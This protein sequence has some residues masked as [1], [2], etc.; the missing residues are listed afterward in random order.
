MA[1]RCVCMDSISTRSC[2]SHHPLAPLVWENTCQGSCHMFPGIGYT[3]SRDSELY[4][5]QQGTAVQL[6]IAAVVLLSSQSGGPGHN[7][8]LNSYCC[9]CL[10]LTGSVCA[11]L[12]NINEWWDSGY[13]RFLEVLMIPTSDLRALVAVCS[14]A[15]IRTSTSSVLACRII[16]ETLARTTSDTI[17]ALATWYMSASSAAA[18]RELLPMRPVPLPFTNE[19]Y[20]ATAIRTSTYSSTAVIAVVTGDRWKT[21]NLRS[22]LLIIVDFTYHER[23]SSMQAAEE[24]RYNKHTS[25]S[26]LV[27]G[28]KQSAHYH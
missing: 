12:D 22:Q 6:L 3:E 13:R 23:L 8:L 18:V 11:R 26:T 7:N 21:R 15:A 25:G 5:V 1:D 16:I 20:P 17:R 9:S 14:A 19:Y 28:T 4:Q 27:N 10:C 2:Q 24:H